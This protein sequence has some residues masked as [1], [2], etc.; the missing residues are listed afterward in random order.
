MIDERILLNQF[1]KG[2]IPDVPGIKLDMKRGGEKDEECL[3]FDLPLKKSTEFY[4]IHWGPERSAVAL[5][6]EPEFEK[7]NASLYDICFGEGVFRRYARMLMLSAHSSCY[8]K[9]RGFY[10]RTI[11]LDETLE[12]WEYIEMPECGSE[13][14]GRPFA[15]ITGKKH[16][17]SGQ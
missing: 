8:R 10:I 13:E 11:L 1:L 17:L 2:S 12:Q 9:K 15:F 5:Y 16:D 7:L 6:M 3:Y 4:A 14:Y